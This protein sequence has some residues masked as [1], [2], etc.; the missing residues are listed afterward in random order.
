MAKKEEYSANNPAPRKFERTVFN[1]W[2]DLESF[3]PVQHGYWKFSNCDFSKLDFSSK[4]G[5]EFL[6]NLS[7]YDSDCIWPEEMAAQMVHN[8]EAAKDPGL[9]I[10]RLGAKGFTGA[11]VNVA[12]IDQ[13][14]HLEHLEYAG[15]IVAYHP[16]F[17]LEQV[18]E[19][20]AVNS[21]YHGPAVIS[22]LAGNLCGTAPGVKLHYWA[23]PG[24][25]SKLNPEVGKAK[26]DS[27]REI[28]EH[29]KKAI[30]EGRED[31]V[32]RC[33]SCSWGS[34]DEPEFEERQKL[35]KQ[36]EENGCMV[37]GGMYACF[38]GRMEG[39]LSRDLNADLND[40]KSY[41]TKDVKNRLLI[42]YD[43]RTFAA[44][45]GGYTYGDKGGSSWVYPY[46]AGVVACA[47]QA[48]AEILK[49]KNWQNKIWKALMKTGIPVSDNEDA[50]RI[51][52]PEAFVDYIVN[53]RYLEKEKDNKSTGLKQILKNAIKNSV[54]KK[55][56]ALTKMKKRL[57]QGGAE[58]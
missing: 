37:F 52:Q 23:T 56:P 30:A 8:L 39:G 27:L 49:E 7:G 40:V 1:S 53:K 3:E 17:P 24:G 34:M 35:F 10:S 18:Q 45:S 47:I 43:N 31:D 25:F 21:Q 29:N 16:K 26:L 42:P 4:K 33:L 20:D 41:A 32:I 36:I 38:Q 14:A 55:C 51:I 48:N 50:S 12:I 28:L 11:N 19:S 54:P 22:L 57:R 6:K 9:G 2:E 5:Q 44:Q 15:K 58:K 46:A 13:S